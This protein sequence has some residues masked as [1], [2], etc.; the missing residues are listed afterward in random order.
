MRRGSGL[1]ATGDAAAATGGVVCCGAEGLGAELGAEV[2]AGR[3]GEVASGRCCG[4]TTLTAE[5]A[6]L[7][8][9]M[10]F[11][12]SP[13]FETC[14]QSILGLASVSLLAPADELPDRSDFW[15]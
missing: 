8:A 6:S 3:A 9:C 1:A 15:K 4:G 5:A 2:T 11:N 12:T 14:D 10:A 7:R 13:G